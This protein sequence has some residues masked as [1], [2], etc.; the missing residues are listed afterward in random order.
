VVISSTKPDSFCHTWPSRSTRPDEWTLSSRV[1]LLILP[2]SSEMFESTACGFSGIPG[3]HCTS[4]YPT[5]KVIFSF[6]ASKLGLVGG[7]STE[8]H[9]EEKTSSG[10]LHSMQRPVLM[11]VRDKTNRLRLNV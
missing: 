2:V 8:S 3:G 5:K 9:S 4:Y 10:I 1:Y 11:E 7:P 6:R